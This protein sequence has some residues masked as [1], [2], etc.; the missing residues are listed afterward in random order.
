MI[1]KPNLDLDRKNEK[2]NE[3]K[4]DIEKWIDSIITG[5]EAFDVIA[6]DLADKAVL[7]DA[8]WDSF[9][10]IGSQSLYY[11]DSPTFVIPRGK[12]KELLDSVEK[13]RRK[14]FEFELSINPEIMPKFYEALNRQGL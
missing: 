4:K 8:C 6:L 10:R 11:L 12:S 14:C 7:H 2:Y 9:S 5:L 13:I 1:K 3:I